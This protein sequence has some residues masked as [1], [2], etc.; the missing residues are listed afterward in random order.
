[1]L[2]LPSM[3]TCGIRFDSIGVERLSHAVAADD[4]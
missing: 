3:L 4:G 2:Y 1:M